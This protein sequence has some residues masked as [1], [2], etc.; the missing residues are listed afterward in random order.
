[1]KNVLAALTKTAV[2]AVL[3]PGIRSDVAHDVM[4]VSE[5]PNVSSRCHEDG[6]SV[7][8]GQFFY[9]AHIARSKESVAYISTNISDLMF[10]Q[11]TCFLYLFL[12][13]ALKLKR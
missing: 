11:I 12:F 4:F 7:S 3:D 9:I 1:M 13:V 8:P 6:P 5:V 10:C 2:Q